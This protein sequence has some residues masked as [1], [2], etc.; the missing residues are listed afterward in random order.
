MKKA[1]GYR[2]LQRTNNAIGN[3]LNSGIS[4]IQT[5]FKKV[6]IG[7][8]QK[9]INKIVDAGDLPK[10]FYK[11]ETEEVTRNKKIVYVS[12]LLEKEFPE[13]CTA[14]VEFE[15][16]KALQRIAKAMNA[17]QTENPLL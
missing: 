5:T 11:A 12:V 9:K 2:S 15:I 6:R 8:R 1:F 7:K 13:D 4:L 14:L 16:N 3:R 17:K 10:Q